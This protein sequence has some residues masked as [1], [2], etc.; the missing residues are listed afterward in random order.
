MKVI[1][2]E[3]KHGAGDALCEFTEQGIPFE[4]HVVK[5]MNDAATISSTDG[6]D[7]ICNHDVKLTY[8]DSALEFLRIAKIAKSD[9]FMIV[10][11]GKFGMASIVSP[12]GRST[13]FCYPPLSEKQLL[14]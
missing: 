1:C 2:I 5:S 3:G 6:T 9:G 12:V 7:I 4:F 11:G 14:S 10:R 13:V 8:E